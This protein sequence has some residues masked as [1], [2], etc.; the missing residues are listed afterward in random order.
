MENSI[1]NY[2]KFVFQLRVPGLPRIVSQTV[3]QKLK[4]IRNSKS[5]TNLAKLTMDKNPAIQK[6]AIEKADKVAQA[7]L[8]T[9]DQKNLS[10]FPFFLNDSYPLR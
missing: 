6:A 1:F 8:P 7:V 4:S 10:K 9:I 2:S 5:L 3:S